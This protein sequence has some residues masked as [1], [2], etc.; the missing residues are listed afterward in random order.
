MIDNLISV[1]NVSLEYK[2]RIGFFKSFSH[3]A[4]NDI[5]FD[6][7]RGEVFGVLG[8]NGSGKST[9]LQ[10]LAG[11]LQPDNGKVIV[12]RRISRS[13]L[14]L[15]L[16]F[17]P[18][19][20][21][22]DNALISCMLNGYSKENAKAI[23]KKIEG[24][25]ELGRFFYQPVKTYSAGMKARLGFSTAVIAHV[26]VL[27]IDEVL[28]VGDNAFK[29]KAQ[30]ALLEKIKGEQTVVFVSHSDQQIKKICDRCI[31]IDNGVIS[32][33]GDTDQVMSEYSNKQQ[34]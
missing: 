10:V 14:S 29:L 7:K 21:G 30:Q 20:T 27:L 33:Y 19:L 5:S 12:D 13:L 25:S 17:N 2:S 6:I 3:K 22:E 23:L 15:G 31:W 28:S 8:G 4:L 1:K 18:Q 26:D 34:F 11:I 9:L 16:G 32:A 24:F